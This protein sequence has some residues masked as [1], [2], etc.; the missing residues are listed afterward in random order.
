MAGLV[1][2]ALPLPFSS[3]PPSRCPPLFP[4]KE[5]RRREEVAFDKHPERGGMGFVKVEE[6]GSL[7]SG[8]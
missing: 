1:S 8:L 4:A 3:L 7:S 5:S 6:R 2:C